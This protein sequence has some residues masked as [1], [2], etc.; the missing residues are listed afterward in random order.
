MIRVLLFGKAPCERDTERACE[1]G[2]QEVPGE[3]SPFWSA[4]PSPGPIM[5]LLGWAGLAFGSSL[6]SLCR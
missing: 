5:A 1:M 3:A 2:G 4:R 6:P